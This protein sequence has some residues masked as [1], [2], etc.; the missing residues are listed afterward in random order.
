MAQLRAGARD[1]MRPHIPEPMKMVT[2]NNDDRLVSLIVRAVHDAG[3][4]RLALVG[5]D[6]MPSRLVLSLCSIRHAICGLPY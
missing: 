3:I 1:D 2:S 6:L 4:I 5:I